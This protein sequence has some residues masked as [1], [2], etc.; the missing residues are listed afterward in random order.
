MVL[1]VSGG[2]SGLYWVGVKVIRDP[3]I[4]KIYEKKLTIKT[5][6]VAVFG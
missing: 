1:R 5:S 2:R 4:S 3:G 6:P